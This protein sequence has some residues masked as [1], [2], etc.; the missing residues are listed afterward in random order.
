MPNQTA[1]Y[2]RASYPPSEPHRVSK[3]GM[4][5]AEARRLLDLLTRTGESG[6]QATLNGVALKYKLADLTA[7][8]ATVN[9]RLREMAEGVQQAAARFGPAWDQAS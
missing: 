5:S 1:P 9:R 7:D 2:P 3:G 4:S 8:A 6:V